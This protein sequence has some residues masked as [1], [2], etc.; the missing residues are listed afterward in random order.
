M[1]RGSFL[2]DLRNKKGLSQSDVA[3]KLGYTP[4]LVSL[5]EKDRAIPDLSIISK[6]AS[7]L[8][9]DLEGFINCKE[10]K[11]NDN[12]VNRSFDI[13]KFSTNLRYLRK[14]NNLFQSDLATKLGVNVKTIVYWE[15]GSSIPSIDNFLTLCEV[16]KTSFDELYFVYKEE[17]VIQDKKKRNL[18]LPIFLPI[19]ITLAIGGTATGIVV[20]V[21]QRNK[22]NNIV[23]TS[24]ICNHQFKKDTIEPSYELEGK[25]VYTCELCG[26]AYEE[27]IPKLEHHYSENYE[28]DSEYHYH[29]CIDEGYEDLIN[30]KEEHH[31]SSSIREATFEREG[32]GVFTCIKC[33]YSY[34]EIYPKLEH[35]YSEEWSYTKQYHYHACVDEGYEDLFIDKEDHQFTSYLADNGVTVY[36]CSTCQYRYETSDITILDIYNED[37]KKEYSL[38]KQNGFYIKILNPLKYPISNIG[39]EL[40]NTNEEGKYTGFVTSPHFTCLD[41]TD[42]SLYFLNSTLFAQFPA[43]QFVGTIVSFRLT[44]KYSID[45]DLQTVICDEFIITYIE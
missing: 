6:Y 25:D 11:K 45:P 13:K 39:Y 28:Y 16:F 17:S 41:E 19:V 26:Y 23:S 3:N 18:F 8:G 40:M 1:K 43:L 7:L 14:K 32:L 24:S 37:G 38:S 5:W 12:C 33:G 4:Q 31:F 9:I 27:V 30:D 34:E 10:Q 42:Y 44:D 20:G 29:R 35:H 21:N 36:T 15:N 22:N 2:F